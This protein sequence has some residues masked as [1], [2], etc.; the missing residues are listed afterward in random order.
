M[1]LTG[2]HGTNKEYAENILN[3]QRFVPSIGEKHWLGHGIYFYP[4]FEDALNWAKEYHP[5]NEAVIHALICVDDEEIIDFDAPDGK[6]LFHDIIWAM[7]EQLN[8]SET[9]V[10]KNQCIVCNTIWATNNKIKVLKSHFGKEQTLFRTLIDYREQM[11]ELCVRDNSVIQ[12]IC[13]I[14]LQNNNNDL[15]SMHKKEMKIK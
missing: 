10:Q 12:G 4:N 3:N 5:N 9:Q 2:Y 1:Y 7:G 13:D 15:I 8:L 14:P 11:L 6:K